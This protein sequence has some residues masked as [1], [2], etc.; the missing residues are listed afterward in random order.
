[1]NRREFIGG[2][3]ATLAARGLADGAKALETPQLKVGILSDIHVCYVGAKEQEKPLPG[4][5][6][7][8]LVT[9]RERGVDAVLI[10]GDFTEFGEMRELEAVADVW[11]KVFPGNRGA[12]GRIVE[13]VFIR[14]N[15]DMMTG[16]ADRKG[17]T[18][19][20]KD[21]PAGAF[22]TCFGI[23]DYKAMRVQEVRGYKFL[24]VEWGTEWKMGEFFKSVEP[25]LPKDKPFFWVQHNH[26]KD[27]NIKPDCDMVGQATEALR[28]WPNAV[29]ISG[30]SHYPLA[31]GDQIWQEEFTAVGASS[32]AYTFTR[33]KRAERAK[34]YYG[35]EGLFMSV[36]G[37][38]I[39][40]ERYNFIYQTK[41]GPDWVVP[42]D[43][44]R[45]Y[46]W[47]KQKAERLPPEFPSGASVTCAIASVKTKTGEQKD[48]LRLT[49]PRPLPANGDDGR[50]VDWEVTAFR[51]EDGEGKPISVRHV[52]ARNWL[53]SDDKLTPTDTVDFELDSLKGSEKVRFAVRA[54]NTWETPGKP[55]YGEFAFGSQ[56]KGR[57]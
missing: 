41:I 27:T 8:A 36:Y 24:L 10:S 16:R 47:A 51:P 40:F 56:G 22:R 3:A 57:S 15:H 28:R 44:S 23:D 45:P 43:G 9:F 30:H 37:D 6:E 52:Y 19:L 7:R 32:L 20:I 49:F 39:V 11:R 5:L 12:D 13:R 14:G 53:N 18:A 1:M 33:V 25:T 4:L 50:T 35:K 55:I 21:D 48:V 42:L 54:R 26:P 31:Y 17:K 2:V 38:R 29:A 34:D 46:N